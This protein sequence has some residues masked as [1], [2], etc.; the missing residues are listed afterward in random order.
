VSG[1]CLL[2]G[3]IALQ[4]GQGTFELGW[5]HS[6][7]K[8]GW[9]E[10]WRV[11]KGALRLTEAAVKGSGA[12]MEPGENAR[13]LDGWW[14]WQPELPPVLALTLATSGA[15]DGGWQICHDG[16]CREIGENAGD[17]ITVKACPE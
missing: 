17:P 1:A 5:Q 16:T 3:A 9:R 6:V 11:E 12:G 13:L 2:V 8:T 10:I 15:T 4:L 14:V 7:E